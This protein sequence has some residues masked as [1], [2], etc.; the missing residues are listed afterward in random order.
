MRSGVSGRV[1]W[2]N[3]LAAWIYETIAH[4]L[5]DLAMPVWDEMAERELAEMH[6]EDERQIALA[7]SMRLDAD[8]GLP[9]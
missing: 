5:C 2:Y 4:P 3:R 6:A 9:F 7:R 1:R 8:G